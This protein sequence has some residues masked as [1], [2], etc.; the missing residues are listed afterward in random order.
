MLVAMAAATTSGHS[1]LEP[2]GCLLGTCSVQHPME[3]T[4]SVLTLLCSGECHLRF[5]FTSTW[6]PVP[7]CSERL[8]PAKKLIANRNNC[9]EEEAAEFSDVGFS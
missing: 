7:N 1:F 2:T 5:R 4:S 9:S 6:Q 3:L 8:Q